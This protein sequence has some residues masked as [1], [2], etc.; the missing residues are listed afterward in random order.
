MSQPPDRRNSVPVRWAEIRAWEEIE[1]LAE[2]AMK[3]LGE[4]STRDLAQT[5]IPVLADR[6]EHLKNVSQTSEEKQR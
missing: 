6:I 4:P 5:L 1:H 3:M 2:M